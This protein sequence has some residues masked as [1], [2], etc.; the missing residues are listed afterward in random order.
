MNKNTADREV[1]LT[2]TELQTMLEKASEEGAR[3]VLLQLGLSD[4]DAGADIRDL[5]VLIDGWRSVKKTAMKTIIQTVVVA[6]LSALA[7][8]ATIKWLK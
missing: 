3:K 8:G 6:L 5:R 7:V 4:E 2:T 1:I